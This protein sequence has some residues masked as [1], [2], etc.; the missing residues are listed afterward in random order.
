[1]LP[2]IASSAISER[3]KHWPA[4]RAQ[5]SASSGK[6]SPTA[7]SGLLSLQLAAIRELGPVPGGWRP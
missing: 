2:V 4:R 7:C 3:H 5:R 6:Q 1:M